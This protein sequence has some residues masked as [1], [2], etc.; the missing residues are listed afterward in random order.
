[1][2]V[3]YNNAIPGIVAA[4][5]SN[6]HFLDMHPILQASDLADGIHPN[7]GGYDK[8]AVA[9][10]N[11]LHGFAAVEPLRIVTA[12]SRKTHGPGGNFDLNLPL[13]G[14]PGVECRTG[15]VNRTYTLLFTFSNNVTSG[16]AAITAGSG[17]VSGSPTFTGNV[18]SVNLTNVADAQRMTL[19]LSGVK[20]AYL[21]TLPSTLIHMNILVGDTTG[22]G[23]VNASDVSQAKLYV[24]SVV[25]AANFRADVTVDNSINSSDISNVRLRSGTSLP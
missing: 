21:Q 12:V 6:F 10:A 23:I 16:S 11:A 8:M 24:G 1:V 17:T 18:M 9:W 22:D 25:G 5:G 13:T 4:H 19:T 2:Q 14:T 20:D 15:G 7:Q 3:Q